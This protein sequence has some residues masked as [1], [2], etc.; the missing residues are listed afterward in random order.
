LNDITLTF[1]GT[2]LPVQ[3]TSNVDGS[4]KGT[5]TVPTVLGAGNITV[6]AW[7]TMD[8]NV[9]ATAL[10][11]YLPVLNTSTTTIHA[12]DPLTIT[13]R[14]FSDNGYDQRRG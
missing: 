3:I 9:S 6:K 14:H 12:G 11:V 10:F 2:Y 13:G 1:Q 8:S 4:F 7:V 5:F